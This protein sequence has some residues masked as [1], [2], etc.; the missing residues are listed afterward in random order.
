PRPVRHI[1]ERGFRSDHEFGFERDAAV[2]AFDVQLRVGLGAR[3]FSRPGFDFDVGRRVAR[4]D[5]RQRDEVA[6]PRE[7]VEVEFGLQNGGGL[8]DVLDFEPLVV[9]PRGDATR[10]ASCWFA[11]AAFFEHFVFRPTHVAFE[12]HAFRDRPYG[13]L[14]PEEQRQ[15]QFWWRFEAID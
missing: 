9:I 4:A 3:L 7:A 14:D 12:V 2:A 10:W 1:G 8:R 15:L 13:H 5:A 6:G 11:Y